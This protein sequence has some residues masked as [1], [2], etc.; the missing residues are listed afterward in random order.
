MLGTLLAALLALVAP[1]V[2]DTTAT[3]TPG[4]AWTDTSGAALQMHGLGI[5]KSGGTWYAFGENKAGESSGNTSFQSISCYSSADLSHWTYQRAAL[6]VQS[7]GDLG[8]GR[9]VER[10]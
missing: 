9:I 10:P 1:A 6:S 2:A 3:L 8:P 4:A 5:V 7:S